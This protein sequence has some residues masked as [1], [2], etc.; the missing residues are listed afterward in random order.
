MKASFFQV[1][2]EGNS[3]HWSGSSALK[4]AAKQSLSVSE[5]Q[6][7]NLPARNLQI[8]PTVVE[9]GFLWNMFDLQY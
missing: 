9:N 4:Y 8:W 7:E 6:P 1:I 5:E 3:A 2:N